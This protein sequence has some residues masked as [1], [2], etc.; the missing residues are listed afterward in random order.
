MLV[1]RLLDE[2]GTEYRGGHREA[3]K[4]DVLELHWSRSICHRRMAETARVRGV[5]LEES[6]VVS[7]QTSVFI[8][9]TSDSFGMIFYDQNNRNLSLSFTE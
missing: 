8:K 6:A 5:A 9:T 7:K 4:L 2:R 1:P 3:L